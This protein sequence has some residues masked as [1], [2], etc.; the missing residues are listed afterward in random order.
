MKNGT[1]TNVEDAFFHFGYGAPGPSQ[2]SV[3]HINVS[4]WR[5]KSHFRE[6]LLTNAQEND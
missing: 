4:R 3:T 6:L 2:R 5:E 1:N